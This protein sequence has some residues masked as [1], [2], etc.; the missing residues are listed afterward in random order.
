MP[1]AKDFFENIHT[2]HI[3]KVITHR[4]HAVEPAPIKNKPPLKK[5]HYKNSP[6]AQQACA[7]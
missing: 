1:S 2:P 7:C 6:R 5:S 3:K 4:L